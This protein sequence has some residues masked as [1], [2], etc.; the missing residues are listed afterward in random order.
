MKQRHF[1]TIGD[2]RLHLEK[3]AFTIYLTLLILCPILFGAVHPYAY[4]L[5]T[6]GVLAGTCLLLLKDAG[7]SQLSIPRTYL[8]L[9]S[10]FCSSTS[11][12]RSHRFRMHGSGVSPPKPGGFPGYGRMFWTFWIRINSPARGAL[13]P[14]MDTRFALPL[15]GS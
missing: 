11:F 2:H 15:S 1:Y 14:P 4:T 10:F 12:F 13:L 6:L 7:E 8:N 3:T 9:L 5:M